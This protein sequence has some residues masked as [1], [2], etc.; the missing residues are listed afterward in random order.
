MSIIDN[1]LNTV[2]KEVGKVQERSQEMM[3]GF[4]LGN[5]M[6]ELERKK[7]AKLIEMGRAIYDKY[8]NNKEVSED[9]L[10]DMAAE[11]AAIDHEIAVLQS[12]LDQIKVKNDPDATPSQKAE[13]RAGYTASPGY[14]CPSCGAQANREK[15]FCPACGGAL[16]SKGENKSGGNG[17]TASA[18]HGAGDGTDEV[19]VEADPA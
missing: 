18:G 19:E 13:A 6:R 15:A 14:F 4:N 1:V 5:Q 16:K 9:H 17:A 12:E 11:A 3:Q 8:E 2:A 7:N 10:K